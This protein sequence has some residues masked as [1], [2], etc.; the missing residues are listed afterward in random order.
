[1]ASKRYVC[2]RSGA[3]PCHSSIHR[4]LYVLHGGSLTLLTCSNSPPV[5]KLQCCLC[6]QEAQLLP[7]PLLGR[8]LPGSQRHPSF[9]V[10]RAVSSWP[11]QIWTALQML[12][13]AGAYSLFLPLLSLTPFL[14]NLS[15]LQLSR[16]HLWLL[17]YPGYIFHKSCHHDLLLGL[18]CP[19]FHGS[20][21]VPSVPSLMLPLV[22]LFLPTPDTL[23]QLLVYILP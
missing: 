1:M 17:S 19:P 4:T 8:G 7:P 20:T 23:G 6:L 21:R 9:A 22:S 5:R 18:R 3:N 14:P 12:P 11:P 15:W 16:L 2:P 10:L 13:S